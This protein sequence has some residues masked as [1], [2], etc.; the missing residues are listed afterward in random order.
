MDTRGQRQIAA[1]MGLGMHIP[2][3]SGLKQEV[4]LLLL[5]PDVYVE[6]SSPFSVLSARLSWSNS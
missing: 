6:S 3:T 1:G 4:Q 5:H 2:V